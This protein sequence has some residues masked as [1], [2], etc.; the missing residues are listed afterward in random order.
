MKKIQVTSG[1]FHC[2]LRE[3]IAQ[4]LYPM[5]NFSENVFTETSEE[6][7]NLWEFPKA[8]ELLQGVLT[9]F[10]NF[11]KSSDIFQKIPKLFKVVFKEFKL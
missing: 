10:E 9:I 6:L 11:R 8:S 5:P 1:M 3:S 7:G 4:L 2:I